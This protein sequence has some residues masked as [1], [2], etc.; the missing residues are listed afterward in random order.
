MFLSLFIIGAHFHLT[1]AIYNAFLSP[2]FHISWEKI[3]VIKYLISLK[4]PEQWPNYYCLKKGSHTG[5]T[6][7]QF[8]RFSSLF[9]FIF[10]SY[11]PQ[12][13]HYYSYWFLVSIVLTM[14]ILYHFYCK[15]LIIIFLY[16]SISITRMIVNYS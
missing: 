1:F 5:R 13:F 16:V 11:L 2:S 10:K 15:I 14:N 3:F 8:S 12:F 7:S 6:H 9:L 4:L